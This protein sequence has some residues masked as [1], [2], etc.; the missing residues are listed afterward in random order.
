MDRKKTCCICQREFLPHRSLKDRQKTCADAFC[1]K[2][3]KRQ[4]DAAWRKKNPDYFKGRYLSTLKV[5]HQK[6]PEYKKQYRQKH[7]EYVRKNVLYLR[8]YRLRKKMKAQDDKGPAEA[9]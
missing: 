8:A 2:E 7:P 9:S 1:R 4:L 5:W 6:N 3:L